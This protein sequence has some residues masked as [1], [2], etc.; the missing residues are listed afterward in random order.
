MYVAKQLTHNQPLLSL[1]SVQFSPTSGFNKGVCYG[2]EDRKSF[3]SFKA[4]SELR[5]GGWKGEEGKGHSGWQ[6]RTGAPAGRA[7]W[8]RGRRGMAAGGRGPR[9][10]VL[11]SYR[12]PGCADAW[13]S[14]AISAVSCWGHKGNNSISQNYCLSLGHAQ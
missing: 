5:P 13:R 11:G 1:L 10:T 6:D 2:E 3:F 8:V 9:G 4:A 12:N 14:K 7:G